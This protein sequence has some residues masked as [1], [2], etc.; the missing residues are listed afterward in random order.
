MP[1]GI[2]LI[3][4]ALVAYTIAVWWRRKTLKRIH[5]LWFLTGFGSD[6]AG[7]WMMYLLRGGTVWPM[8]THGALG[9]LALLVMGLHAIWAVHTCLNTT[10]RVARYFHRFSRLAYLCWLIAFL[11]GALMAT[12]HHSRPRPHSVEA[13]GI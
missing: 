5:L 8:T 7:T 11:T 13:F 3:W 2:I 12:T 1:K 6:L 9:L 10:S 4:M